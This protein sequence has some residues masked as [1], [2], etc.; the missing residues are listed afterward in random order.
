MTMVEYNR[1]Q[2]VFIANGSG[3]PDDNGRPGRGELETLPTNSIGY[4]DRAGALGR[5]RVFI[6]GRGRVYWIS[7]ADFVKYDPTQSGVRTDPKICLSCHRL[8]PLNEFAV[9]QT[10][11]SGQS[12]TRPR[13]KECFDNESGKALTEKAKQ[14]FSKQVGAPAK[15]DLWRCP[16]CRK[17]SIAGVTAQTRVDHDQER[18]RPRGVI[19]DSCNTGLGRFKNG[20]DHLADAAEYLRQY[21]AK[22]AQEVDTDQQP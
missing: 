5:S 18:Q 1:S 12:T 17:Y 19:C 13:C 4:F 7:D 9:N 3:W 20:M 8:K 11:R 16:C 21:E 14:D 10:N 6:V 2:C 15:G 22:V